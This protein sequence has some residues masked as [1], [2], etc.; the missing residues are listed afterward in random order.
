MG[1]FG[2]TG[3]HVDLLS[4]GLASMAVS[5]S[6]M[7]AVSL[8]TMEPAS[9]LAHYSTIAADH[10][11]ALLEVQPLSQLPD[12]SWYILSLPAVG[13]KHCCGIFTTLHKHKAH[14]SRVRSTLVP[15]VACQT[16]EVTYRSLPFLPTG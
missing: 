10:N 7:H 15:S 1:R 6:T 13:Y 5:Q 9:L 11:Y 14:Y 12:T 8:V 16:T 2:V 3:L 4:P